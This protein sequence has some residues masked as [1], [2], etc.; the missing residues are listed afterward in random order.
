MLA[1][2]RHLNNRL[3]SITP[4]AKVVLRNYKHGG[5]SR[6][7]L[8]VKKIK[9]QEYIPSSSETSHHE[10]K[11]INKI[12]QL[13]VPK[14]LQ[15]EWL[16]S[17]LERRKPKRPREKTSGQRIKESNNKQH[18]SLS[19]A[20]PG[21]INIGVEANNSPPNIPHDTLQRTPVCFFRELEGEWAKRR[22]QAQQTE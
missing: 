6:E 20:N 15:T 7:K 5:K 17:L 8:A 16:Y 21:H 10:I 11:E 18:R 13:V 22:F 2:T 1:V 12:K 19:Q 4:R 3:T 9:S 14:P